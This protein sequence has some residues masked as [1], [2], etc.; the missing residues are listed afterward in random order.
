MYD[1]IIDRFRNRVACDESEHNNYK[2]KNTENC[3]YGAVRCQM[4]VMLSV[5]SYVA[6]AQTYLV[7][8][9]MMKMHKLHITNVTTDANII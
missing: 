2:R 4:A 9:S 3:S 6:E 7:L 1:G 8:L 5:R